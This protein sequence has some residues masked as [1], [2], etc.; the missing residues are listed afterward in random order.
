MSEKDYL[1]LLNNIDVIINSAAIVK[2][3]GNE[4]KFKKINVGLTEKLINI[5]TKFNKDYFMFLL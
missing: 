4:E 5:C 2:H 3:Y 1:E